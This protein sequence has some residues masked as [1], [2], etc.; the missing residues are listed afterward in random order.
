VLPAI[1]EA[2]ARGLSGANLTVLNGAS[3]VNEVLAGLIGQGASIFE[4][5]KHS[6]APRPVPSPDGALAV[7]RS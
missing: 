3:G 2:A 4:T 1:V 6:T 5:L 7:T